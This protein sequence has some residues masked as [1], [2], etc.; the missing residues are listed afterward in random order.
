MDKPARKRGRKAKNATDAEP[1]PN[2]T[3]TATTSTAPAADTVLASLNAASD[4]TTTDRR[5]SKRRRKAG[6]GKDDD[7]AIVTSPERRASRYSEHNGDYDVTTVVPEVPPRWESVGKVVPSM[8][9][10]VKVFC[11]HTEP[12]F[13]LPWQR[14]RQYSSSSSGFII[15]GR[16]V[17]T[18]AHSVEHHT[19]VKVKKR[20]SDTKYLATVL[21]IGTECDIAM[22]TVS[23]DEFWEGIWPLEFG[24]LPALQDAVTVVGYPIGGDTISVT[25]GVVS[26]IEILS[27]VHGSTELLGLQI[28]AAIN[29]G[30]SGG[31]AFNDKGEC[32]G[33]AFQ[34]LKHEDAEN[35]G[36]V[37]PTP[38]IT[39]FIRDYEKNGDY[40]GFP[41]L[42]VEWQKME[43]PDLRMSMGMGNE[44]KGVRIKRIEP[45]APESNVLSPSDIILS[46]DGVNV[47][48]DGTVPFRHGERIGFSYLVSQKYTG[49]KA[50]VKI[51]R[52][53]KIHEF[54]IKLA[55]HKRLIPAHIGGKPP[56]YYIIAGFVFA[57]VSVP[58]LRSE[59]GKDYD[60]DAPVKLLD[61]H[62][63]AMA[64]SVD[65]QLVVVSQVLVADINIGYEEIVNTQVIAFNN[66]P[67]KNLKSL[68][69]MVESCNE[70][71]LKFDLEYE[72]IV[73]L[74]TKTA[75]KAT[76]DILLT[77]CIPSAMSDDLK[78]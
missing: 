1:N 19:Q 27:Y 18:N 10:V 31:P 13:S 78:S 66:K 65:E 17:L 22:L 3:T 70:E 8:D 33:I 75:K 52:N 62:L 55:T 59:Y 37:I 6:K 57:A 24:D 14:K 72:Q 4:T 44:H 42:G 23:D 50:L 2:S 76:R 36:Y 28:D 49:D 34:S 77:H 53:S 12:N 5:G 39:H 40:T 46:F 47:A 43:N 69:D 26:R 51:L 20:G 30:N 7:V 58:Y 71:F 54:N 16:R 35:I 63:H 15:G 41:I 29:S 74:R 61:K 56:S 64:E 48:N 9:A 45:T 73:V 11:V 67:V 21:A 25:S 68:A 38:V 32:V 60:F